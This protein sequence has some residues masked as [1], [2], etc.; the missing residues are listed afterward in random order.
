MLGLRLM[1]SDCIQCLRLKLMSNCPLASTGL[2]RKLIAIVGISLEININ[3]KPQNAST[4]S[5]PNLQNCKESSSDTRE[6]G[7]ICGFCLCR[8]N[9]VEG[10]PVGLK[11]LTLIVRMSEIFSS[12]PQVYL[13]RIFLGFAVSLFCSRFHVA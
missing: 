11:F 7:Q 10:Q 5:F 4:S 13:L 1:P 6:L 3:K 8:N 12:F 9:F 2:Y